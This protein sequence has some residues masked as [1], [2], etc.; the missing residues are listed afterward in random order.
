VP[1]VILPVLSK[2]FP[3][4]D[5]DKYLDF[6]ATK[7][8]I[9]V[10]IYDSLQKEKGED[11]TEKKGKSKNRNGKNEAGKNFFLPKSMLSADAIS[12]FRSGE[13]GPVNFLNLDLWEN[14]AI[15]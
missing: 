10:H 13:K 14:N 1:L 11:A 8:R 9:D 5:I 6:F 15:P 2:D 7:P 3:I 4:R 12:L